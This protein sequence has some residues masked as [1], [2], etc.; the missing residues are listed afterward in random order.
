MSSRGTLFGANLWLCAA[1]A[2]GLWIL[3]ATTEASAD[4]PSSVYRG[5]Y[6]ARAG[7][8]PR[9]ISES[10]GAASDVQQTGH[11]E[12]A[13]SREYFD[14]RGDDPRYSRMA[15]S[16]SHTVH[17]E[18]T[19]AE[20]VIIESAPGL[21]L[22]APEQM[23]MP[24]VVD[25][26]SLPPGATV[27]QSA[28]MP[29]SGAIRRG[30]IR[31]GRSVY[32]PTHYGA[33]EIGPMPYGEPE[34]GPMLEGHS[35]CDECGNKC[36]DPCRNGCLLDRMFDGRLFDGLWIRRDPCAC[37]DGCGGGDDCNDW[38][39]GDNMTLFAGVHGFKSPSDGGQN[40]NFGFQE[41]VNWGGPAWRARGIGF[42]LGGQAVQSNLDGAA[43]FDDTRSQFFVTAG[44]FRRQMCGYGWQ[45][46]LVYDHMSDEFEEEFDAS[47][48]R[49][50]V[51]YLWRGHE[52]GLWFTNE[53]SEGD[54][55]EGAELITFEPIDMYALFYRRRMMNGGEARFWGGV[56]GDSDGI[57]GADFRTPLSC[58]W[59]L[60]AN[61]N[62]IIPQDDEIETVESNEAWNIGINLVWYVCRD[63]AL[64]AGC[65]P[66]RPLLNVADNGTF[67]VDRVR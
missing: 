54:S 56:T 13:R 5:T 36:C 51:S 47:Q 57:L 62:Y 27:I 23:P 59:E 60:V 43:A 9:H 12:P 25:S 45:W 18:P 44:F 38:S 24:S 33:A 6:R 14:P 58:D 41:G 50:E 1:V 10:N 64:K 42:Q 35:G 4:T 49:G 19:L 65:S 32:G 63:G 52:L 34:Y 31:R 40:G 48:A 8:T 26:R 39:I 30:M 67:I 15:R 21:P 17:Q 28:P 7:R 46:G 20:G 55:G 22:A 3:L 29:P 66:Y 16:I 2:A 53:I 37:G 11:A 61:F